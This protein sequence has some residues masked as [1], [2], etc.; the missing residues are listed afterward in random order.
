MS[1]W[2]SMR[3]LIWKDWRTVWSLAVAVVAFSIVMN[4][5]AA[6]LPEGNLE[7]AFAIWI[8]TPNLAALGA[9]AMLVGTEGDARTL[10]WL[11][12]LPP[13]WR[14][15]ADAKLFVAVGLVGGGLTK[16]CR[17]CCRRSNGKGSR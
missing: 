7:V 1:G 17:R 13:G 4:G 11:R 3:H 8:L 10:D 9:P 16:R 15:I 5:V 6:L 14:R 2:T 12:T